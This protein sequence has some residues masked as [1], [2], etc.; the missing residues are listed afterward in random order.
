MYYR[1]IYLLPPHVLQFL[2]VRCVRKCAGQ[3]CAN[4]A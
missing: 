1:M 3:A 4:A 2:L